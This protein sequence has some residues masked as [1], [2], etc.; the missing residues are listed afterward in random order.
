M[1]TWA[2][3]S[4]FSTGHTIIT[5]KMSVFILIS[6]LNSFIHTSLSTLPFISYPSCRFHLLRN[7]QKEVIVLSLLGEKSQ[8]LS[9]FY[10][11]R[12]PVPH[13]I[14]VYISIQINSSLVHMNR[15]IQGIKTVQALHRIVNALFFLFQILCLRYVTAIFTSFYRCYIV[16]PSLIKT[17]RSFSFPRSAK[18]WQCSIFCISSGMHD[19]LFPLLQDLKVTQQILFS[20]WILRLYWHPIYLWNVNTFQKRYLP[21]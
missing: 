8:N 21:C 14:Y 2:G 5:L 7:L 17:F 20:T 6:I 12:F 9:F 4:S 10:M 1:F 3:F 18:Y 13:L 19:L 16:T 15:N 11:R